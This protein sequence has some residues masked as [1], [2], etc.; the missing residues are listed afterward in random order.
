MVDW[1]DLKFAKFAGIN[2]QQFKENGR[3]KFNFRCPYCGDS[4]KNPYKSRG[5]LFENK[6]APGLVFKCHNCGKSCSFDNFLKDQNNQLHNEYK[7]EKMQAKGQNTLTPRK[8]IE[9]FAQGS[10]SRLRKFIPDDTVSL[11]ERISDLPE[12]HVARL[13]L[14]SRRIPSEAFTR[15]F[16]TDDIAPIAIEINPEYA[17]RKL[18]K[19]PR[20]VLPLKNA[21]GELFGFNSRAIDDNDMRY[22]TL[23][24][25]G[26]QG[27]KYYGMERFN[28][29]RPGYLVEGPFDSEFLPNC[30]A[31]VGA[32]RLKQ[33]YVPFDADRV[34]VVFDNQP[35]NKDLCKMIN[36]TINAGFQVC[37]WD[38]AFPYK[39]LNEAVEDG[40]SPENL[41]KTIDEN[42]VK[43]LKATLKFTNW[44][45]CVC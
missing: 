14:E 11:G 23:V 13:Y 39:D 2:L 10:Q 18:P 28:R 40:V 17:K 25:E 42:S 45:A 31:I 32:N 44:K 7:L 8:T 29:D 36:Q 16:Y 35:R 22:I 37:I 20:I 6:N 41:K 38:S 34:T 43:G 27:H 26:F 15:M 5:Y 33:G 3:N 24:Q 4:K 21:N 9:Q 1:I 19:G 30:L 12:D